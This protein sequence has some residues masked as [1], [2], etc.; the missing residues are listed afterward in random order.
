MNKLI[1]FSSER[2]IYEPL[3]L[4]HLSNNY[5]KWLNDIDVIRFMESGGDYSIKKLEKYLINQERK[6]IFFWA[7]K[8][9]KNGKHIGNIKIDPICKKNMSGEYGIM[10]G[11]KSEWGK[12]Y[13]AESSNRIL[14][15]CFDDLNL[16]KIN[17]GVNIQNQKAIKLYESLGFVKYSDQ[18]ASSMKNTIRM[19]KS[20]YTRK[21]V[22]GTAQFGMEYGINNKAGKISEKEIFNILNYSH[23]KGIRFL[24]TA[25][26][27][28]NSEEIIGKFHKINSDKKFK[29]YSKGYFGSSNLIT[30][31]NVER[32]LSKLKIDKYEGYMI[33]NFNVLND[34]KKLFNQLEKIK[35]LGLIK[36]IGVSVYTNENVKEIIDSSFF[37]FVQ[38]PFNLLDNSKKRKLIIEQAKLAGI[39]VYA[40]SLFLQG[41]FFMPKSKLPKKLLPLN[42]YLDQLKKICMDN[43]VLM[44]DLSL[45]YVLGKNYIDKVIFGVD[46]LDQLKRNINKVEKPQTLQC[47]SVDSIDVIE[48]ELLNPVN[49]K[50]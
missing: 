43:K 50:L 31:E 36:N 27:Y 30:S 44:E 18:N 47:E 13:A 15:Y 40:R 32:N 7:I 28:G 48:K 17:L 10:I 19:Y 25:E 12:G 3:G 6:K 11:D 35:K 4:K 39:R 46:N 42:K 14:K 26:S 34:N 20:K 1:E 5:V 16:F 23:S 21:I 29:I 9:K 24:D 49:W 38:L 45:N 37:D 22:L 8:L 33:H 41:L 2:L